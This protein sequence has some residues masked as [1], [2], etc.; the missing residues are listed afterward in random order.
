MATDLKEDLSLL[1]IDANKIPKTYQDSYFNEFNLVPTTNEKVTV[2]GH[3]TKPIGNS[4]TLTTKRYTWTPLYG[5]F[6]ADDVAVIRKSKKMRQHP[7][8][9]RTPWNSMCRPGPEIAA[10]LS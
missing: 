6:T 1:K 10:V 9:T 4:D 2:I 8:C 3:P 7:M 5:T